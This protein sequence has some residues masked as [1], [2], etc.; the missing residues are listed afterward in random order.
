KSQGRQGATKERDTPPK[1]TVN[2]DP[3]NQHPL[4]KEWTKK[5]TRDMVM[6]VEGQ[7]TNDTADGGDGKAV[8]AQLRRYLA[9]GAPNEYIMHSILQV[10]PLARDRRYKHWMMKE[11]KKN[12]D[13]TEVSLEPTTKWVDEPTVELKE[14]YNGVQSYWD[15]QL[16][17]HRQKVSTLLRTW[18]IIAKLPQKEVETRLRFVHLEE[19]RVSMNEETEMM[20]KGAVVKGGRRKGSGPTERGANKNSAIVSEA[21]ARDH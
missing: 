6:K 18:V 15:L 12:K 1:P 13:W 3:N 21:D 5:K 17:E 19:S 8:F 16:K 9:S 10:K 2:A 14:Q 11:K 4:K 20:Y 7:S